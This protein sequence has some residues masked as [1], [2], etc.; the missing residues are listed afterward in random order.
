MTGE[1]LADLLAE[2]S[3]EEK[4]F[5][6][7][8]KVLQGAS[9][10]DQD[11]KQSY[12]ILS[13]CSQIPKLSNYIYRV[14]EEDM[15]K[16]LFGLQSMQDSKGIILI[17]T[18]KSQVAN[19]G[20][21]KIIHKI[22]S[23]I[24][25]ILKRA[26]S[27]EHR[28]FYLSLYFAIISSFNISYPQHVSLMLQY[29]NPLHYQ[30]NEEKEK[31][32]EVYSLVLLIIIKNLELFVKET[33]EIISSYL[34]ILI[35]NEPDEM[36]IT[37]F[38][39]LVKCLESLF[40]ILPSVS[41][42]IYMSENCKEIILFQV[43]K[44]SSTSLEYTS[45]QLITTEILK[46]VSSSCINEQCRSFNYTNYLELL[47]IGTKLQGENVL[48]IRLLSSLGIIKLW[49]FIQLEKDLK[50]DS[51][52]NMS[53]L[54][55]ILINYLRSADSKMSDI[56]L[57]YCVEG[58]AYLSLNTSVK[59]KLRKDEN[60]I[61]SILFILKKKTEVNDKNLLTNSSLVYGLLLMLSNLTKL[62]VVTANSQK[63]TTNYLKNFATPNNIDDDKDE[64]QKSIQNFNC[65]LLKDYK[66]VD[67][68][69]KIKVY[70]SF[71]SAGHQN[72]I[73][74]QVITIISMISS[75]QDKSTKQELIKQGALN[76]ILDY[77]IKNSIVKKDL[78]ETR[79]IS[80]N[81]ELI[82][83]RLLALR[84]LARILI[85]VN[86]SLAFK[87]YD[88]K[89]CIPFLIELLGPD[90]SQYTGSLE[91][92]GDEKYLY[93]GVS[94]L[95]KYE[96]LLALTNISAVQGNNGTNE[97]RKLIIS[98]TFDKYLDNFIIDSDVPQIQK[99]TWEL[100]SNLIME[101]SLLVKFFNIEKQDNLKRLQLLI[102]LLNST[103]ELLQ[104]V[105]GGLIANATSE[106]EMISQILVQNVT[107]KEHLMS[108]ITNIFESQYLNDELLL[109]TSYILLNSVYC[110]SN[111]GTEYADKFR[112]DKKLK[113]SLG[114]ALRS[115]KNKE[116]LAIIIEIIK[117][118]SFK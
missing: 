118:V 105:I 80:S 42:T 51:S 102:R 33:T 28:V 91:V 46:L 13:K 53:E 117:V 19:E 81:D 70:K 21:E 114:L 2:L 74:S 5:N 40:P 31:T 72:N 36:S 76:I 88:I 69:S 75:S 44:M 73:I 6:E 89:T 116:I 11:I 83:I 92:A 110:A 39:N 25:T 106:F 1:E 3:I 18:I 90:I 32:H 23:L 38:L 79:P 77:L 56:N 43:S 64:N 27:S 22:L 96:S 45:N 113:N 17:N 93:D 82:E 20:L 15:L 48:E 35:D 14:I 66:V 8:K 12:E 101:P 62:E 59:Q 111:L 7:A 67:I 24:Q 112:E 4:E 115:N 97:L 41:Y 30:G 16:F 9:K 52:I 99:A 47:K 26:D 87:K 50:N 100:I 109:R 71:D 86:P 107:L 34:E 58:L 94:N 61:E 29:L 85:S 54:S 63:K 60:S 37:S 98:K 104:I 108:I 10:D 55:D 78:N 84:S 103:D 65:S 95:D 49:N 57:E 68:M